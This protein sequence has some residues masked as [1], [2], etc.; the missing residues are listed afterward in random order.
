MTVACVFLATGDR[1]PAPAG[2]ISCSTLAD[3]DRVHRDSDARDVAIPLGLIPAM[4][5]S[6]LTLTIG[7]HRIASDA[8]H[9]IALL[10]ATGSVELAG[11]PL[12]RTA[13]LAGHRTLRALEAHLVATIVEAIGEHDATRW[14]DDCGTAI[15]GW[16]R[17][18][19]RLRAERGGVAHPE[20][21]ELDVRSRSPS[22]GFP[23]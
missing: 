17:R 22:F 7:H 12:D 14:A 6:M 23:S 8:I 21:I 4:R 11:R 3:L 9:A 10:R 5:W 16:Q 15:A 13:L 18:R 20:G 1:F 19:M 2:A